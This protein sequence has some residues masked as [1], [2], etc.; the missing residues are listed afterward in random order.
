MDTIMILQVE[1]NMSS[2]MFSS[3]HSPMS[4]FVDEDGEEENDDIYDKAKA[5]VRATIT[6]SG[7]E[8]QH[9][10]NGQQPVDLVVMQMS[11]GM[12]KSQYTLLCGGHREEQH[13]DTLHFIYLDRH[14]LAFQIDVTDLESLL[15]RKRTLWD[16]MDVVITHDW[17]G[18]GSWCSYTPPFCAFF[19][20]AWFMQ[21]GRTCVV[22]GTI[23][24]KR[25]S[26]G[27]KAGRAQTT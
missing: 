21:G 18:Q 25:R 14:L 7:Q 20:S 9:P 11:T 2:F 27:W 23:Q 19:L 17:F 26:F 15:L 10:E 24:K 6:Q 5:D 1:N 3:N 13:K 22:S 16:C 4:N 12:I 8:T